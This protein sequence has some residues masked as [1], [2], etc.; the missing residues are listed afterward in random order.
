MNPTVD[1]SYKKRF[2]D[3]YAMHPEKVVV[4]GT[5]LFVVIVIVIILVS[6]RA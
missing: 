2:K 3:Y 1:R 4:A 5:A 6:T